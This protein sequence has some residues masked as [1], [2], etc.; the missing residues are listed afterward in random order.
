[1]LKNNVFG[2]LNKQLKC[3]IH[4]KIIDKKQLKE[5]LCLLCKEEK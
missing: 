1:M 5:Q 3:K 4:L 2:N